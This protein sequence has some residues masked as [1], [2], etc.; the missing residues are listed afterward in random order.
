MGKKPFETLYY[1]MKNNKSLMEK[2]IKDLQN[3]EF[4]ISIYQLRMIVST[5][6]Y[7]TK[8]RDAIHAKI[9]FFEKNTIVKEVKELKEDELIKLLNTKLNIH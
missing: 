9:D 8:H 5:F 1:S 2:F 6:E 7:K 4:N 3:P